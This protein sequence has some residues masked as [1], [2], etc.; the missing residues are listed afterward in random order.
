[1]TARIASARVVAAHEGTAEL[2]VTVIY[3]NGGTTEVALDRMASEALL[4]S[5]G[6]NTVEDLAGHSWQKVRDA[7]SVSYNRFQ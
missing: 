2:A 6:A 1:M 3:D 5:C 4:K 7:L